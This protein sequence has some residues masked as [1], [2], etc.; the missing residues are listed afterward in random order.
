MPD[1][2]IGIDVEGLDEVIEKFRQ[3]DSAD[4]KR[5]MTLEV[6]KYI[7]KELQ[8]VPSPKRV[9]RK[10]A[11]GVTFFSDRQ[12]RFFFRALG[13]GQIKVPYRRT[14]RT[15]RGWRIEPFGHIDHLVLNETPG[16]QYVQQRATQSRMM[17]IIGWKTAEDIVEKGSD[18]IRQIAGKV[19]DKWIRKLRL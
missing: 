5:E 16:V 17:K 7:R 9:T 12:R 13:S 14:G 4:A 1:E 2:L 18:K 15:R 3:L 6:A 19:L 8:K 10:Q 11:F